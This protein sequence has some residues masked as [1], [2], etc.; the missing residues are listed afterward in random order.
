MFHLDIELVSPI[1]GI[2]RQVVLI[3][4][5]VGESSVRMSETVAHFFTTDRLLNVFGLL[6][7]M[8]QARRAEVA[9]T[10]KSHST[11]ANQR[12]NLQRPRVVAMRRM[13]KSP[14]KS[15]LKAVSTLNCHRHLHYRCHHRRLHHLHLHLCHLL[16]RLPCLH[17]Q[18]LSQLEF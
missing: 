3:I 1:S 16:Y 4:S 10:Q 8:K 18:N 9:T 14:M 6:I 2:T 12:S 17:H 13:R 11:K 5:L 15:P 7:L